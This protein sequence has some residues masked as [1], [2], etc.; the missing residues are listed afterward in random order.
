MN[1]GLNQQASMSDSLSLVL[2]MSSYMAVNY[3]GLFNEQGV[4]V[5]SLEE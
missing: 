4:I 3:R 5:V 2:I 1:T